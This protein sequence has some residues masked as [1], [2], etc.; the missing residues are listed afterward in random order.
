[1][2]RFINADSQLNI[3]DGSI[4]CNLFAYCENDPVN[5][6]D[7]SGHFWEELWEAFVV[8]I[9]KASGYF[10]VA[11][12]VSQVD[13]PAPGPADLASGVLLLG[14]LLVCMG[15]ATYT[16]LATPKISVPIL[17]AEEKAESI[18]APPPSQTI[19]YRYGGSSPGN[20]TPKEKDKYSGLSF[21]TEPK[22]GAVATTI[23]ALN[24]T[25]VVYAVQDGLTT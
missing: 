23:E 12:G 14:G 24:A 18:Y 1:M 3:E 5:R 4:G 17:K 8:T 2:G 7:Y 9:Q 21:S 6:V 20:L 19:I 22:P 10:A 16:A 25:G 13:T 15:I 11:A